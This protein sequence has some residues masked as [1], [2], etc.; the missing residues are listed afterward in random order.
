MQYCKKN[1]F[2][3]SGLEREKRRYSSSPKN[4]T[5]MKIDKSNNSLIGG[6]LVMIVLFTPIQLVTASDDGKGSEAAI[7]PTCSLS[8]IHDAPKI[9]PRKLLGDEYTKEWEKTPHTLAAFHVA[10]VNLAQYKYP[11][12]DWEKEPFQLF[13]DFDISDQITGNEGWNDLIEYRR[14]LERPSLSFYVDKVA[15]KRWLPTLGI[16]QPRTFAVNYGFELSKSNNVGD[17]KKAI[18]EI[19]VNE[20]DYAAKPSHHSTTSGVW[21]VKKDRKSGKV[22]YTSTAKELKS[23]DDFD[24]ERVAESLAKNVRSGVPFKESWALR[25]AKPGIVVEELFVAVEGNHLPPLEFCMFTIWGRLWIGQMNF[26][27]DDKRWA[28]AFIHRDGTFAE[29][30]GEEELPYDD[31]DWEYLVSIAERLGANKDMFRADIFVGLPVSS[32]AARTNSEERREDSIV[33]VVSESEIYPTTVFQDDEIIEEGARLWIAGYKIG[34][35][36]RVPNTE[37]P[38]EFL[39]TGVLSVAPSYEAIG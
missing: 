13:E 34:N 8:D 25:N 12:E 39:E 29:N 30:S 33:Y 14:S 5:M 23:T 20:V 36:T 31:L 21:L 35:Y 6:L 38:K 1:H 28:G 19:L 26:V 22:S 15:R 17:D 7:S 32:R 11:V 10:G 24:L 18:M 27:K 2:T 16:D 3:K 37:I 4:M 9:Q